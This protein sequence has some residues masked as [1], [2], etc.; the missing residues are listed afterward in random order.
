MFA[1]GRFGRTVATSADVERGV[2]ILSAYLRDGAAARF[3]LPQEK[4]QTSR[5]AVSQSCVGNNT[6]VWRA[7][8]ARLYSTISATT[9][10][11]KDVV[12]VR[13]RFNAALRGRYQRVGHDAHHGRGRRSR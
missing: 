5:K 10:S 2:S 9:Q 1:A 13:L 3:S 7:G 11:W 12:C 6:Q 8:G 4:T